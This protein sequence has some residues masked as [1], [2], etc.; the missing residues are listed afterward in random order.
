MAGKVPTP[1]ITVKYKGVFDFDGLYS[2]VIDWAKNYGYMWMEKTYKHKVPS[3]A[4]AEQEFEWILTTNA[5]DYIQYYI[6][7]KVHL[8]EMTEVEVEVDGK[9][10]ALTHAR[11][12]IIMTGDVIFDWQNRFAK[13]SKFAQKLG[14]WY[15]NYIYAKDIEA[16][17][18]DTLT[19]R[20]WD[21]QAVIKK[22]FDL[23]SK[24]HSYKGYLRES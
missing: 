9:K 21:L 16:I 12:Y 5:T 7:M 20:K 17:H 4:G 8:W 23:Q 22:Y 1:T 18:W 19:Y 14:E 24:K 10:K 15:R 2:A 6:Y 3:P 11:L 13:G